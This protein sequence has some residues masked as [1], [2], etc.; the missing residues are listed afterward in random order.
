M[1]FEDIKEEAKV[2]YGVISSYTNEAIAANIVIDLHT[3][4]LK[5]G[6]I[7][8]REKGINSNNKEVNDLTSSSPITINEAPFS[9]SVMEIDSLI[10][11]KNNLSWSRRL[12]HSNTS[13]KSIVACANPLVDTKALP[14]QSN[15]SPKFNI[16]SFF[17][18]SNKK[19]ATSSSS[20]SS[21]SASSG[22]AEKAS[23]Y[24]SDILGPPKDFQLNEYNYIRL[25][26]HT[27][28]AIYRL[29][30]SKLSNPKLPLRDQVIISNLMFW[31]L[32]IIS[33][34]SDNPHSISKSYTLKSH[35]N[36]K[37]RTNSKRMRHQI[38]SSESNAMDLINVRGHRQVHVIQ[39]EIH[40]SSDESEE[41]KSTSEDKILINDTK[42]SRYSVFSLNTI[43]R[44]PPTQ[45][46][47]H[48]EDD[49]PLAMYQKGNL[50][51]QS[52]QNIS[53]KEEE[54][55]S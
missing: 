54:I 11:P 44:S 25:P 53:I 43:H 24:V 46:V 55:D 32:S 21:S 47:M 51:Y 26:I 48:D 50:P 40:S 22:E 38:R 20:S 49:I 39:M 7:E 23:Y 19:K 31:Y 13:K 29:S 41:K 8:I 4:V 36:T 15:M 10:H 14:K 3:V 30:H 2:N 37:R 1:H 18:M 5:Q 34:S 45:N 12:F 17:R 27:E 9:P 6:Q 33:H 28:R 52:I 42:K 16:S 35:F